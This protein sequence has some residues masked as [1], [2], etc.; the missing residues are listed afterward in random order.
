MTETIKPFEGKKALVLMGSPR[1]NG[2]TSKLVQCF[3]EQWKLHIAGNNTV[4]VLEAYKAAIKPCIHCGYCKHTQ[5]CVY[6][7][8]QVIDTALREADFLVVASPV[9]GLGFPAPLKAIFDRTQQYFEAKFSL[10]IKKP[11][12]KHK[13]ALFLTAFGSND[14]KSVEMLQKQLGFVFLL[15]NASLAHT[16]VAPHTDKIPVNLEAIQEEMKRV[17]LDIKAKWSG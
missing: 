5:G 6:D 2:V 8:F 16:I 3:K 17:L 9:Y 15:V 13:Y 7:D 12:K 1:H 14:P 10:G 4:T 11:I